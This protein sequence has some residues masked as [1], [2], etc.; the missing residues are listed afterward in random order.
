MFNFPS[1]GEGEDIPEDFYDSTE[2]ILAIVGIVYATAFIYLLKTRFLNH[3]IE[4]MIY[5]ADFKGDDTYRPLVYCLLN[6][7]DVVA[8]GFI[9]EF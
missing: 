2:F 8:F 6:S 3:I 7:L 9:C 5:L 4:D 1:A